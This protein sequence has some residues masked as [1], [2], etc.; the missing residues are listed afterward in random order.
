MT[1]PDDSVPISERVKFWEEQDKINQ[2]L[3]PRVIRQHELLTG[4][5]AEHENLPA[6]VANAVQ[7]AIA[8]DRE[9]Q[10]RLY[11]SALETA[12]AEFNKQ[13]ENQKQL[14]EAALNA[15]KT[16]F[17]EWASEQQ[18]QYDTSLEAARTELNRQVQETLDR[19]IR[20]M[21]NLFIGVAAASGAVIVVAAAMVSL[22]VG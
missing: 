3:I 18:R 16:E 2:E 6:V 8:G 11:E 17:A 14:Y 1:S 9:E 10:R 15:A 20:R 13:S 4:H 7:Q 19:E 12:K 21:R 22:I 5:I